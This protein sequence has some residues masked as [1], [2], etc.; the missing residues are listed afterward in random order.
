[1]AVSAPANVW[2]PAGTTNAGTTP[3]GALGWVTLVVQFNYNRSV[4]S[5]AE[6]VQGAIAAHG[7]HLPQSM[8]APPSCKKVNPADSPILM[9]SLRSGSI[10]VTEVDDYA[11]LFLAQQ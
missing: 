11:D 3:P 6:D 4:D 9:L 5:A 10:P 1:M 7:K 2:G 8:T